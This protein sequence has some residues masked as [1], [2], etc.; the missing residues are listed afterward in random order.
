MNSTD[1]YT[2]QSVPNWPVIL[3][4]TSL[5]THHDGSSPTRSKRIVG[6]T[7]NQIWPVITTNGSSS[8]IGVPR[9]LKQ[10]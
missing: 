8:M 1:L 4:I 5:P 9:A 3:S 7:R 6:G 2:A 10:P